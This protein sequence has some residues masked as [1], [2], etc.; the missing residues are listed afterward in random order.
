MQIDFDKEEEAAKLKGSLSYFN[1]FFLE[2][3]KQIN[4]IESKPACRESHQVT[5]CKELTQI[6]RMKHTKSN[7]LINVQP[8]SGKTLHVCMWIAWCIAQYPKSNF[9]YV[10]YSKTLAAANTSFVKQIIS[11]D[12]FS[13]LFDVSVSRE[14]REKD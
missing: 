1:K 12:M 14:T 7:L 6:T 4:Y 13:Y 11:S 9:I 3:I 8:G 10:S 2:H 5:I